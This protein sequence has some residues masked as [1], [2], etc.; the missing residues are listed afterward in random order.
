MRQTR[1]AGQRQRCELML[2]GEAAEHQLTL[3]SDSIGIS[4]AYP[5]PPEGEQS[6]NHQP[7]K[8]RLELFSSEAES[9]REK[10]RGSSEDG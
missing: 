8:S 1:V 9:Q 6:A 4:E 5:S 10:R 3:I 2:L 7:A